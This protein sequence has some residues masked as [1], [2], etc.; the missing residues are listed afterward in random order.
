MCLKKIINITDACFELGHQLT[1]FK[2]LTSIIISKPNK[3]S[4]NSSRAFRSIVLLNTISKLIKKVIGERLQFQSISKNFIYLSQLGSLKQHSTTN[5]RVAFTHF[6]HTEW[7]K[8]TITSTLVFDTAQFFLLLNHQLL[9]LIFD[10]ARFDPKV[11]FF[12]CNYLIEKK[13]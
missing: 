9:L 11:A 13:S 1:Y 4:Y 12:F 5:A 10:K 6:I 3:K 8:N 2:V 7:V